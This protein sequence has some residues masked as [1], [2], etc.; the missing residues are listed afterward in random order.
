MII[1]SSAVVA[2]LRN[3]TSAPGYADALARSGRSRMSVA[4]WLE[5]AVVVDSAGDPVASRRFDDLVQTSGIEVVAVTASQAALA[6]QA[7]RDF[8]EGSGHPAELNFGDCVAYA[9]A[10]EA[11][12]PLLFQ[13]NDFIYTDLS[14][15]S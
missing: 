4:N 6:R 15:A 12:E 11:N 10:S 9:L 1:D 2:I 5:A 14:S 8:G 13:G 7:Y 3:E